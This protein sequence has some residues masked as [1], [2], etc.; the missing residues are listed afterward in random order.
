M[1]KRLDA[2]STGVFLVTLA[3]LWGVEWD[4]SYGRPDHHGLHLMA[5]L[6][7]VLGALMAGLGWTRVGPALTER[8]GDTFLLR[9]GTWRQAREWFTV[10]GI[11]GGMGLWIGSTQQVVCIAVLGAGA[12]L[13]VLLFGGQKKTSVHGV[14]FAPELWLRWSRV[15]ALTSL[16]FYV[17][18]YFP[19]H[20]EMRLGGQ[21]PVARAGV[22]RGGRTD[23]GSSPWRAPTGPN[24]AAARA[25]DR[26]PAWRDGP[27]C[28]TSLFPLAIVFGPKRLVRGC[29]DPVMLRAA[30]VISEGRPWIDPP[31]V[32][33]ASPRILELYRRADVGAAVGGGWCWCGGGVDLPAWRQAGLVAGMTLVTVFLGWT[34]LQNRWMGFMETSLAVLA[35]L[36]APCVPFPKLAPTRC[37]R[38]LPLVLLALAVPGWAGYGLL[39]MRTYAGDPAVHARVVLGAMMA[40]KEV[41]WNLRRDADAREGAT[42]PARVMAAP[43]PSPALHYY[44]GVDTVG[45]YYWENLPG[46]HVTMDFFNDTGDGTA[47]RIARERDLDFVVVTATPS[48]VL[49]LQW[50]ALGRTNFAAAR[51][52]LGFRLAIPRGSMPPDWLEEIPLLDAPMALAQGT[53]IFRVVKGRL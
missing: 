2:W 19:A 45:S 41:A 1:R 17:I 39:Q 3:A 25:G 35:L 26:A 51:R 49:E 33:K 14:R 28:G 32:G 46:C 8:I 18:E 48:F 21:P 38:S 34:L 9:L 24:I 23:G 43:G 4:F 12:T 52:T 11:C 7:L 29:G 44:G 37:R 53:R 22:A 6:G 20:M 42:H 16:V 50:L 13:G 15:G 40:T 30:A 36:A 5:F 10:S 31:S 47:R 27:C